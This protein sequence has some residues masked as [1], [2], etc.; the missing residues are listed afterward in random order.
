[1][2]HPASLQMTVWAP[3]PDDAVDFVFDD[4]PADGGIFHGE[5]PAKTAALVGLFHRL[6]L[7][8]SDLAKQAN[9]CVLHADAAQMAGVVI[10]DFPPDRELELLKID[11]QDFVEKFH[12]FVGL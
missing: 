11:L 9:A 2:V 7:D 12:E 10:R 4:R 1:M 6:E 5:R 8:V 3:V